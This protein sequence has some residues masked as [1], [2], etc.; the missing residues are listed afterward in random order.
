MSGNTFEQQAQPPRPTANSGSRTRR[1]RL[2]PRILAA[3]CVAVAALAALAWQAAS[4]YPP[5]AWLGRTLIAGTVG[6]ASRADTQATAATPAVPASSAAS[7]AM[8][9]VAPEVPAAMAR[10]LAELRSAHERLMQQSQETVQRLD[11]IEADVAELKQ[12]FEK[13][14]AAQAKAQRQ[15]R[16]LTRQLRVAQAAATEARAVQQ[17]PPRVLSVDT[18][19]GRPSVSV[20]VGT[21][22]RF[23]SEGD[24]VANA[25]L[26]RADPTTQR[27]EFVGTSDLPARARTAGEGR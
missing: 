15:A 24:M 5:G 4:A 22:V 27:V 19:N 18:W 9:G 21:E 8:A 1:S 11:R 3:S 14:Q 17:L 20:Q 6:L 7:G 2:K 16:T 12:Q 10:Q 26:R 25:L 13:N 23:F